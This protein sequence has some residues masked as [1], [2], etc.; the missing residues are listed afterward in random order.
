M[1][2]T[3][4]QQL[5]HQV[6]E[7]P[8]EIAGKDRLD[9]TQGIFK[10][11]SSGHDVQVAVTLNGE[12]YFTLTAENFGAVDGYGLVY[13]IVVEPGKEEGFYSFSG[14]RLKDLDS[15]HAKCGGDQR[16]AGS[17]SSHWP[18]AE[19]E[20]EVILPFLGDIEFERQQLVVGPPNPFASR[21]L[22]D[23]NDAR[24]LQGDCYFGEHLVSL[25]LGLGKQLIPGG[26]VINEDGVLY[27]LVPEAGADRISLLG[28]VAD[29]MGGHRGG[30]AAAS[31]VLRSFAYADFSTSDLDSVTSRVPYEMQEFREQLITRPENG[32]GALIGSDMG[33]PFAAV[34]IF[35]DR[36][37]A[38]RA[39]DCRIAHFKHV[40]GEYICVW[41]SEDQCCKEEGREHI[42]YNA[43]ALK[44]GKA[45]EFGVLV[46]EFSISDGDYIVVATDGVWKRLKTEQVARLLS[47]A[48]SIK[49][50]EED[51]LGSL[52][53]KELKDGVAD[54]RG[55]FVH[56]HKKQ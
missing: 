42:V 33:A 37:Q 13:R 45:R 32:L 26:T 34:R 14:K 19:S 39:G 46:D 31:S 15:R 40:G 10:A 20:E 53:M 17:R 43:A 9:V 35:E 44:H 23:C 3:R 4:N 54:N 25:S 28:V 24:A 7:I 27:R 36:F 21:I 6:R 29:G 52:G 16:L 8:V 1:R 11:L 12:K 22:R 48:D 56:R 5:A 55:V 49:G 2:D 18:D 38:V 51:L 41:E 30:Q 50:F 47:Q